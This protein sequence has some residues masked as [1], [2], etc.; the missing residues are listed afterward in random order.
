[1]LMPLFNW[2]YLGQKIV[3]FNFFWFYVYLKLL[4]ITIPLS[5]Q[6]VRTP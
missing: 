1:M 6:L 4:E 2:P 5:V 3:N